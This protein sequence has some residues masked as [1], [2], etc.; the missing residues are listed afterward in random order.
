MQRQ[1][2]SGVDVAGGKEYGISAEMRKCSVESESEPSPQK[3]KKKKRDRNH[4]KT[5]QK[6][7]HELC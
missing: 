3:K 6:I 4:V 1:R 2:E 5:T 7:L